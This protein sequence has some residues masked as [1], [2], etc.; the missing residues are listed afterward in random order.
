MRKA[1]KNILTLTLAAS[2]L[3]LAIFG[4]GTALLPSDWATRGTLL[5]VAVFGVVLVLA[6]VAII[7][8]GRVSEV[9]RNAFTSL[10]GL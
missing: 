3:G 5:V 7:R 9:L 10:L 2:G 4:V 8:G 1:I 6:S